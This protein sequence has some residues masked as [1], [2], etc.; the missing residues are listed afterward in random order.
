MLID[1]PDQMLKSEKLSKFISREECAFIVNRINADR[2]D[3]QPEPWN[4]KKW[5]LTGTDWKIWSYAVMFA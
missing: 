5:I 1:F 2:G 3:S 4:F